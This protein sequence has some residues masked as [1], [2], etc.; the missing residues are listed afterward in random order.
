[1]TLDE[2]IAQMTNLQE[3]TRLSNCVFTDI[4]GDAF[5]VIDG[6][7]K[8]IP[9]AVMHGNTLLVQKAKWLRRTLEIG[10]IPNYAAGERRDL[11]YWSGVKWGRWKTVPL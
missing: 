10:E 5:Q 7:R 4:Y 11:E 6:T 2:L 8:V 3:F 9:K 1:M